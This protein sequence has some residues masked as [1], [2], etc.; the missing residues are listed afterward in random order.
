MDGQTDK[1][2][3]IGKTGQTDRQDRQT[4]RQRLIKEHYQVSEDSAVYLFNDRGSMQGG[5][6]V[7]VGVIAHPPAVGHLPHL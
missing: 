2:G 6:A 7:D 4:G 1:A 3:E 5:G